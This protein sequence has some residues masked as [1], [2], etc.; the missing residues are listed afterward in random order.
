MTTPRT[1]TFKQS[2]EEAYARFE[3]EPTP[4]GDETS[5]EALLHLL[6]RAEKNISKSPFRLVPAS[7]NPLDPSLTAFPR[8]LQS[9][10]QSLRLYLKVLESRAVMM[11]LPLFWQMESATY[12]VCRDSGLLFFVADIS[13]TPVNSLAIDS[14]TIDTI[15]T[16]TQDCQAVLSYL[17]TKQRNIPRSWVFVHSVDAVPQH[18]PPE[19]STGTKVAQEVHVFP[20]VPILEQCGSLIERRAKTFH[21]SD[22]YTWVFKS[23][24]TLITSAGD[25]PLPFI[26]YRLPFVA[27]E[28]GVCV[29]GK[30]EIEYFHE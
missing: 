21:A 4:Y 15:I 30:A 14:L 7:F 20:G 8:P 12:R 5:H 1:H 23:D 17:S 9:E 29:C 3:I 18:I 28:Q 22:S 6:Q 24:R 27:I 26:R 11:L 10:W 16:T 25:D 19:F 13:N 2:P